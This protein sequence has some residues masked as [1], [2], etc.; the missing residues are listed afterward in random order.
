[1]PF[2]EA[3]KL[4][5]KKKSHFCCAICHSVGV[6]IHHI[7]P[8]AEAIDDTIDNAAPLCPSCHETYGANPTK[9][10]FIREARDFWYELCENKYSSHEGETL[11]DIRDL[12]EQSQREILSLRSDVLLNFAETNKN[13]ELFDLG[14]S[15]IMR[16]LLSKYNQET[17]PQ[18]TSL[19]LDEL[20]DEDDLPE[21]RQYLFEQYG[22]FLVE[23]ITLHVMFESE[24]DLREPFTEDDFLQIFK[25]LITFSILLEELEE[26][27]L[28]V[29]IN[30]N[31]GLTWKTTELAQHI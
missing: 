9:R 31:G 10:K 20:W 25:S 18:F 19:F 26:G 15:G 29:R 12:L 17:F 1:M 7:I 23:K 30:E 21:I 16:Y 24:I 8:Q 3:L 4:Q 14:I 6:E 28:M 22:R 27:K 2:T 11:S 13:D 5:I